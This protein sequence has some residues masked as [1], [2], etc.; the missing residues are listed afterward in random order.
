MTSLQGEPTEGSGGREE[1][2]NEH[3][4]RATY[5]AFAVALVAFF[6]ALIPALLIQVL[7][8]RVAFVALAVLVSSV[9][10]LAPM[11]LPTRFVS[12]GEELAV[13]RKTIRSERVTRYSWSQIRRV[14]TGRGLG[15]HVH[16]RL[17][18]TN[19]DEIA[20]G[21]VDKDAAEWIVR[22]KP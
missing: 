13:V 16:I 21:M 3:R 18:L 20:I 14:Q 19:G 1:R 17:E 2:M 5:F 11:D 6:A 9:V 15:H 7:I 10:L 12:D 4:S 22:K 8:V